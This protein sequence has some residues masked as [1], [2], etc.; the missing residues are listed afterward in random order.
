MTIS[1]IIVALFI[2]VLVILVA[3]QPTEFRVERSQAISAPVSVVFEQV[4]NLHSWAAWS[5]W[6]K[7]EPDVKKTFEG[8]ASGIGAS[9][10]WVGKK[11]GTGRMVTIE[12][13]A[14]QLLRFDLK[15]EKPFKAHNVAEFTFSPQSDQTLVT[16]SMTGENNLM[17]KIFGLI[18]NCNKMVGGQF[19]E[20]LKNL[21]TVS[22]Q[23]VTV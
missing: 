4:S 13:K 16:W 11:T 19:E 8:P 17:G 14:A 22:E 7:M 6:D 20:G 3:K 12:S 2:V 10:A 9:Y 23:T 1:L 18:V 15:F 21:K 5:P